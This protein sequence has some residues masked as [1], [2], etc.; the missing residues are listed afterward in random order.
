M[1]DISDLIERVNKTSVIDSKEHW[2][3]IGFEIVRAMED[4]S[5]ISKEQLEQLHSSAL[6][7]IIV[8]LI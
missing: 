5:E 2:I 4:T 6:R 8:G 7:L 3:S 1:K